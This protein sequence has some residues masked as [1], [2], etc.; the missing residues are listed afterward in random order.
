MNSID[1]SPI[2]TPLIQTV[3]IILGI[4]LPALAGWAINELRKRGI[5][6]V[7]EQQTNAI[8]G[9]IGTSVGM[10]VT[11]VAQGAVKLERISIDNPEVRALAQ[12]V[13]DK[14]PQAAADQGFTPE[15]A[16][17]MIVGGLGQAI[18]Q[19][20]TIPTVPVTTTTDATVVDAKGATTQTAATQTTATT[21]ATA[22]GAA[23]PEGPKP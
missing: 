6:N 5:V 9:A 19:D 14:V 18:S 13:I 3:G 7:N 10:L 23:D 8:K 12:R 17:E 16:A 20:S 2:M 15:T 11:R 1:L 21:L 22:A 4:V